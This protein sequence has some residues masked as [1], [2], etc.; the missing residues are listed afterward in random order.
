MNTSKL[1]VVAASLLALASTAS[2]ADMSSVKIS[3]YLVGSYQYEKV[4]GA[5]ST[6]S[7]FKAPALTNFSSNG[8]S[9]RINLSASEGKVSGNVSLYY[10]PN[11]A[12]ELA[13]DELGILDAYVTVA[14]DSGWSVTAGKFYGPFGYEPYDS[15]SMNAITYGNGL[16]TLIPS[17]DNIGARLDYSEKSMS[18]SI[19]VVDSLY[20]TA[21]NTFAIQDTDAELKDT[22]A[23]ELSGTYK[24][25]TD[26]TLF[27]AYGY[28]DKGTVEATDSTTKS[29]SLYDVWAS[30]NIS[31]D[32]VGALEYVYSTNAADSGAYGSQ[33]LAT[34]NYAWDKQISTAFR[35]GYN[36]HQAGV[37]G[38]NGTQYTIAPA[39]KVSDHFSVRGEF[40][41]SSINGDASANYFGLQGVFTF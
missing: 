32:L 20:N 17:N 3:G 9:A 16:A 25:I 19:A 40:S 34:L 37:S 31:S 7:L 30:Y 35:L 18:A 8:D 23:I 4:R 6:D 28:Q 27:A 33:W 13:P 15:P 14:L 26:L 1:T 24:G 41:H 22:K 38:S 12:G 10:V 11:L 21:G 36:V 29:I 39:Y 5:A 2:A